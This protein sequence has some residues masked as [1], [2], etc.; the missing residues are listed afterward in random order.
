MGKKTS[1]HR[2]LELDLNACN[3]RRCTVSDTRRSFRRS[4]RGRTRA[5]VG[6]LEEPKV[7]KLTAF[8]QLGGST[9]GVISR[10]S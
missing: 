2:G 3:A 5:V 4:F 7:R 10:D 9:S 6:V 1:F 8:C